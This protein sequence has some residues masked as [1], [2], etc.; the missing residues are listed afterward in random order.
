MYF[1]PISSS[2][3]KGELTEIKDIKQYASNGSIISNKIQTTSTI[4]CGC[5]FLFVRYK[6]QFCIEL[7][8]WE[9]EA[10]PLSGIKKVRLWEV[11]SVYLNSDFNPCHIA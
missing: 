4:K 10:C 3:S 9:H 7:V 2:R 1:L 5:G 6:R 8:S 11:V